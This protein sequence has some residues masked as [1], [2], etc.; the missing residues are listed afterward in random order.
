M[1]FAKKALVTA[2]LSLVAGGAFAAQPTDV[3]AARPVL[4]EKFL[5]GAK[6][7]AGEYVVVL[8][9]EP[10][11]HLRA[12][13]EVSDELSR[14]YSVEVLRTYQHALRGFAIRA[15]EGQAR[16]LAENPRVAYV[17]ENNVIEAAAAGQQLYA[18]WGLDRIDQDTTQYDNVYNYPGTG[19]NIHAYVV[20]TGIRVTH[21]DFGGRA[22]VSY[23]STGQ[24]QPTDPNYGLDCTTNSH[25]TFVAGLIGGNVYGVAKQAILHSV[26]VTNCQGGSNTAMLV[27][28][29]D[30]VTANAVKPAVANVSFAS[31]TPD[32]VVDEAARRLVNSG[33]VVVAAG[34]NGNNDSCN[35][36]PARVPEVITVGATTNTDFRLANTAYGP[37]LDLFAPGGAVNSTTNSSDTGNGVGNGT[38]FAAPH[39]SGAV[40]LLLEQGLAAADVQNRLLTETV[41]D[42]VVDPGAGSA[43]RLLRVRPPPIVATGLTNGVGISVSDVKDG[44]KTFFLEVPAGLSS[45]TFSITGGT[46]DADMYVRYNAVPEKFVYDC[47]PYRSTNEET[48]MMFNPQQGR[49]YVQLRGGANYTT[50]LK[51][52][53]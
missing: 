21:S 47:R 2:C 26:R 23:D 53:Y 27:A 39:V 10:G 36:S 16:A 6:P 38:S 45:V 40:A 19:A 20:D 17:Q 13:G 15:T 9:E 7:V 28:G 3:G 14:Q 18:P 50:T 4:A 44:V 51:G 30:W 34:G 22:S 35:R 25:G 8:E 52:Q 42:K 1:Q 24:W 32:T 37:C 43:N 41:L 31:L 33:V 29:L 48:C 11:P 5:R 46:G 12:M 49:W